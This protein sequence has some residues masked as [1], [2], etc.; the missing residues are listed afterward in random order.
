MEPPVARGAEL[1]ESTAPTVSLPV[2]TGTT[3]SLSNSSSFGRVIS[4]GVELSLSCRI[5]WL[6]TLSIC[7]LSP[8]S[9]AWWAVAGLW[10][11]FYTDPE[12]THSWI[13][14]LAFGLTLAIAILLS[15]QLLVTVGGPILEWVE[16]SERRQRMHWSRQMALPVLSWPFWFGE[17]KSVMDLFLVCNRIDGP[18]G[19]CLGS[20][21]RINSCFVL[22]LLGIVVQSLVTQ[23]IVSATAGLPLTGIPLILLWMHVFHYTACRGGKLDCFTREQK[24]QIK[25]L[26]R[27]DGSNACCWKS[28][29]DGLLHHEMHIAWER[30][31][32]RS[33]TFGQFQQDVYGIDPHI[34]PHS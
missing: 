24:Q 30:A 14:R 29:S 11:A 27:E 33:E 18:L 9:L 21:L 15:I 8:V 23:G 4:S 34:D 19:C 6:T 7:V 31:G 1:S 12:H 10:D 16:C 3:L 32:S 28:R 2:G 22:L 13:L 20:G 5:V 17:T 25:R 26:D